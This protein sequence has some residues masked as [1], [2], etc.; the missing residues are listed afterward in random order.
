MMI[1]KHLPLFSLVM[2]VVLP[3]VARAQ[4][5]SGVL[6]PSRAIDWSNKG[7][8]GGIPVR[9]TVC[10]ALNPGA[11]A[12]QINSAIASCPANQVVKLN[13]GTYTISTIMISKSNVTLRGAGPDQTFLIFTTPSGGCVVGGTDICIMDGSGLYP[14]PPGHSANWTAGYAKGTTSVTL[15]NTTGLAVGDIL[16]LDQLDDSNTDTG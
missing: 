8:S 13:A 12:A 10:A 5:W 7:A 2:L 11:T 3:G 6:S 4:A 15:D 9:T 14:L 16:V 1:R